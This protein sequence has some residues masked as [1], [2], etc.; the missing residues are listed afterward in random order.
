MYYYKLIDQDL[1]NRFYLFVSEQNQYIENCKNLVKEFKSSANIAEEI[2]PS[3]RF[4]PAGC[5]FYMDTTLF[6]ISKD[7]EIKVSF[8]FWEKK[9]GQVIDKNNIPSFYCYSLK[10][11]TSKNVAPS[12]KVV[13]KDIHKKLKNLNEE[14]NKLL[15]KFKGFS[16]LPYELNLENEFI[17]SKDRPIVSYSNKKQLVV[18]RFTKEPIDNLKLNELNG[19]IVEIQEKEFTHEFGLV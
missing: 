15:L 10:K 1:I 5:G 8:E 9:S 17:F 19:K 2:T 13:L 16:F 14:H 18:F 12:D 3:F 4:S 6:L 11:A 7:D